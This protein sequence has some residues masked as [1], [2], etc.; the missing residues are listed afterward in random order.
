MPDPADLWIFA[1]DSGLSLSGIRIQFQELNE[2]P[3]AH[4]KG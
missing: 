2:E 1:Q 3:K 4:E